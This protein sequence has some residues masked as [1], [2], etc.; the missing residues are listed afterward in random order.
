M[1]NTAARFVAVIDIGKTNAKL[2]LMDVQTGAEIAVFKT[3]NTVS[4]APPYPHFDTE[5]LFEFMLDSL[6]D[7]AKTH[8]VDAISI[9]THGATAVLVAGDGSLA[10]PVMD[11]E[12]DGPDKVRKAYEDLRP[13]FS[14]TG[15][16]A[17]PGGLNLGS[18]LYWQAVKL[19]E[20]FAAVR[21]ILMYPQYWS[22]RFTGVAA[23]E[24]TSLGC[25]TDLW[26]PWA[27]TFSSLVTHLNQKTGTNW[28]SLFP[29]LRRADEKLGALLPALAARTGLPPQVPVYCGIHDSNASLLPYLTAPDKSFSVVSTGTWV[30]SLAIGAK[31]VTL[32]AARDTL[33]N[34]NAL[35]QPTP[36]ARFMG[37]REFDALT[38]GQSA[39]PIPADVSGI[40]RD[41]VMV[42]P[43]V[44]PGSGPFPAHVS[45]WLGRKPSNAGEHHVAASF[46]CALM[47]TTCLELIG[48]EGPVY[49]EGPFARNELYLAMLDAVLTRPVM[50]NTKASTGTGLGA[51]MLASGA[52]ASSC[53][54]AV[55]HHP[56]AEQMRTYAK[57]WQTAVSPEGLG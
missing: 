11:Y 20:K 56:L 23:S 19:P 15:S 57:R 35:G 51:A 25:H 47:T 13:P 55:P 5:R 17:L 1:T 39:T 40:L 48:A 41:Q 31:P 12:F 49:V 8:P 50:A 6:A 38:G 33:V 34:V 18:Q 44:Q 42:L 30:I 53:A 46:Y 7:L 27:G 54:P 24:A 21:H 28:A 45:C 2:A 26:N 52:I 32:D 14:E 10:L 43:A 22:M 4:P 29:P 36:T 9:T 37:G 3:P 16:P